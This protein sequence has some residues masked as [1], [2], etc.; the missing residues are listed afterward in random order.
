MKD[1]TTKLPQLP[2]A[3][4]ARRTTDDA[5]RGPRSRCITDLLSAAKGRRT[6][7]DD[8]MGLLRHEPSTK[9]ILS[10]MQSLSFRYL[11][12]EGTSSSLFEA[13]D[14]GKSPDHAASTRIARPYAARVKKMS[15]RLIV[16]NGPPS[17]ASSDDSRPVPGLSPGY[18]PAKGSQRRLPKLRSQEPLEWGSWLQEPAPSSNRRFQ[19]TE[20]GMH[21]LRNP[22]PSEKLTAVFC[23]DAADYEGVP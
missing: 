4:R 2:C 15:S 22:R 14:G 6:L 5:R 8:A 10:T 1:T 17:R 12:G 7:L 19:K 11:V 23:Y 21:P 20:G 18:P 9:T 16:D 3:T 13:S